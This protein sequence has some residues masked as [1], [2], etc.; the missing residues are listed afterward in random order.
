MFPEARLE[1]CL[2]MYDHNRERLV[3]G[4]LVYLMAFIT[5]NLYLGLMSSKT[6]F[7]C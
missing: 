1:L 5:L 2:W 3:Y 7:V 6:G 4:A